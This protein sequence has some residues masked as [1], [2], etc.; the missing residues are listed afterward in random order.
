MAIQG[1]LRWDAFF[2]ALGLGWTAGVYADETQRPEIMGIE[3]LKSMRQAASNRSY[4]GVVSYVKDQQMDSFKL[5]HRVLDGQE[6]ERLISM[7]SPI[8]EV[9]RTGGT[10]SRYSADSQQVVVETKPS[11]QSVLVS[12]PEDPA[13][14]ERYYRINLRG[15]EY[16]AGALTQ[17]VALEPRDEYRYSRLIWIDT[18]TRLPLKL[19]VLNEDGQSVEQM[20]FTTINTKDAIDPS[21]LEPTLGARSAITQISHRESQ[22]VKGLK[23]SIKDVPSGFQIVSY[24]TLKRPPSSLPVEHILLSDGFSAVS[25]YIEQGEGLKASGARKM[26]AINVDS[27]QLDR[28]LVTVMGEVPLK[29]VSMIVHGVREK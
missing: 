2:L 28:H 26:G 21:D 16:I 24:S 5:Y 1:K 19:D 12:L 11:S 8:R 4:Q 23:W 14:L 10:V 13:T 15:Q 25:I 18:D 3:W 27:V 6:R 9:V 29:T 20:V 22:P 17:V 7:N